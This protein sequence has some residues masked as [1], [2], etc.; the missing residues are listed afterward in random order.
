MNS[1]ER[2][3]DLLKD[4]P[5]RTLEINV[6]D[7]H[8]DDEWV[9]V[10]LGNGRNKRLY[11]GEIHVTDMEFAASDWVEWQH[12][13]LDFYCGEMDVK[14]RVSGEPDSVVKVRV[15]AEATIDFTGDVV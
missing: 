12:T 15:T 6:P 2:L 5:S 7:Y 9:V 1:D 8:G 10:R 14:V 13:D 3:K 11:Y 4:V